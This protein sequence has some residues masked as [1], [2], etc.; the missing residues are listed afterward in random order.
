MERLAQFVLG[1]LLGI[2]I[3]GWLRFYEGQPTWWG[4]VVYLGT[5]L[6]GWTGSI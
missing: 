5:A 2:F 1:L 6:E 4:L 3:L